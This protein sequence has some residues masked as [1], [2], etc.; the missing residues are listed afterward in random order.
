[1]E[2]VVITA[3]HP[4]WLT[5][6]LPTDAARLLNYDP[7][8]TA[9]ER[10]PGR[11]I[12]YLARGPGIVRVVSA[13][14][15]REVLPVEILRERYLATAHLT[16]KMLHNLPLAVIEHLGMQIVPRGPKEARS[17]DDSIVWFVP[18]PE[19]YEFHGKLRLDKPWTGPLTNSLAHVYI[20]RSLLP[21][22]MDLTSL[23]E[24]EDRIER[25]EWYPRLETV[26]R[27]ARTRA[28]L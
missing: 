17:T 10:R 1:M 3:V 8:G 25:E 5:L 16:P 28:G 18:A 6:Q 12:A 11:G 23:T 19:Y 22:P 24:L 14:E 9:A 2:Y 4:T 20:A 21:L 13:F 15:A 26:Q 27:I 7:G